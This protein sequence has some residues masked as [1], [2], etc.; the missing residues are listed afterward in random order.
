M[1]KQTNWETRPNTLS[2]LPDTEQKYKL[3]LDQESNVSKLVFSLIF[4]GLSLEFALYNIVFSKFDTDL[5]N[6]IDT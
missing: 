4:F 6:P 2:W 3:R 5:P 1:A